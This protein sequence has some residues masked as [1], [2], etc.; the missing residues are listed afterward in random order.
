MTTF[1][2]NL[3]SVDEKNTQ[4][5]DQNASKII[6]IDESEIKQ[7]DVLDILQNL[8]TSKASSPDIISQ[9]LIR[10][11]AHVLSDPLAKLFNLLT[12]YVSS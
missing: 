2:N 9:K 5:P 8:N 3:L 12:L 6:L 10:E 4:L 1:A 11:G 7:Q